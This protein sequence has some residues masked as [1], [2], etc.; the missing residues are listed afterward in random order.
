MTI[1]NNNTRNERNIDADTIS[2][3]DSAGIGKTLICGS[4]GQLEWSS[5]QT[6]STLSFLNGVTFNDLT[7]GYTYLKNNSNNESDKLQSL[8]R[9]TSSELT[10]IGL[11]S[12]AMKHIIVES[13]TGY[14][15]LNGIMSIPDNVSL[16]FKCMVA[17]G[18]SFRLQLQ[19]NNKELPS[20]LTVA[21]K[22]ITDV[23]QGV[24]SFNINDNGYALT[25][26][27]APGD[28][29]AIRSTSLNKRQDLIISTIASLGSGNYN[30]TVTTP[31]DFFDI[32]ANDGTM[33][34]YDYTNLSGA[35]TRGDSYL[36]VTTPGNFAVG[37]Y[38]NI[39]QYDKAGDVYGSQ[40][41][42]TN[43]ITGDKFWYS[44]NGYRNEI[45]MVVQ[46]K[47]SRIYLESPLSNSYDTATTKIVIMRPRQN[48][49]IKGLNFF[50]IQQPTYPR[51][52]NHSILVDTCANCTVRDIAFS[53]CWSQL[54][55]YVPMYVNMDNVL[56]ISQSHSVFTENINISR[57]SN[58]YSDSGASYGVTAY[59]TSYCHFDNMMLQTLRH[60]ILLQGANRCSFN[61]I[62]IKNPLISG[63]DMHGLNARDNFVTNMMIDISQGQGALLSN[64]SNPA[65]TTVAMIRLGNSTHA[66]G[67]SYNVFN[68]IVLK[69]GYIGSN[70]TDV[71][72]IELVPS[73]RYNEFKNIRIEHVNTGININEH[74][75]GRLNSNILCAS[76][77]FEN[78]TFVHCSNV[79]KLNA[80]AQYS[81]SYSLQTTTVVSTTSNTVV[82]NSSNVTNSMADFNNIFNGWI[83]TYNTSNYTVSNYTASNRTLLLTTNL[84]P[85]PSNLS[86]ITLL[87]SSNLSYQTIKNTIFKSC[88][89][90]ENAVAVDIKQCE[91]VEFINCYWNSNYDATNRYVLSAE[92]TN[93]LAIINNTTEKYRR[94]IQLS[95]CSNV[96]V[97]N[98]TMINQLETN[99]FNDLSNNTIL[100]RFNHPMGF[101]PTF[102]VAS[103]TTWLYDTFNFGYNNTPKNPAIS[104]NNSNGYVGIQNSNPTT[105]FHISTS[106]TLPFMISSTSTSAAG[107]SFNNS[108]S[109]DSNYNTVTTSNNILIIRGGNT[110]T[111]F[112][113]G[114]R[115]GVGKERSNGRI[116]LYEPTGSSPFI[117]FDNSNIIA[118]GSNINVDA[119]GTFY[120][121]V[122]VNVEGVGAKWLA[123]YN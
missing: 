44:N 101:I 21:P 90:Y 86:T 100:W 119:L 38:L 26:T 19:G 2:L 27:W 113:S 12:N 88:L 109:T 23:P 17:A 97:I 87:D 35:A 13:P 94:F 39:A 32:A 118:T 85:V 52:N 69:N 62:T 61:N 7:Q 78:V 75:R 56:R 53:D 45:R 112:A 123:L 93:D 117:N 6:I 10:N 96:R 104:V 102:N 11:N 14:V 98:N 43:Y 29:I 50:Y 8:M 5:S 25:S 106:R 15:F 99:V 55:N 77:F 72:G 16:E 92:N 31:T 70:I 58:G 71:Y 49:H 114:G 84:S 1:F 57:V 28:L 42:V 79:V 65:N 22:I 40:S 74:P 67:D 120:G 83:F 111:L 20:S 37:M 107:I 73:S 33:R 36:D 80:Q 108:Q 122:R 105:D 51:K 60:N 24:T 95:N 81:N 115:L 121:R 4:N 66:M 68:N 64:N 41:N 54:L 30:V 103:T 9:D 3:A 34:R 46:I 47:G 91:S 48:A 18:S 110:N 76:N 59:Y 82:I 116:H 89:A 63:F